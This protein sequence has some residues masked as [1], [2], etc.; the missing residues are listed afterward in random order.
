MPTTELSRS[1]EEGIAGGSNAT[2]HDRQVWESIGD[3]DL[4]KLSEAVAR[5]TSRRGVPFKSVEG[6]QDF[7]IDPI[8]RVIDALRNTPQGDALF[9]NVNF[10]VPR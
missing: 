1:F 6:E 2:K 4:K 9:E 8:P 7:R 3:R 5:G 10:K